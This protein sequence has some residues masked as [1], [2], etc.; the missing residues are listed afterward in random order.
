MDTKLKNIPK[1]VGIICDGNGRW[2]KY[3]GLLRIAGH[4]EGMKVVKNISYACAEYGVKTVSIY[5]FS[6]ENWS[7]PKN[8]VD[9]LMNLLRS[10]L[11]IQYL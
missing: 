9:F 1:H 4:K 6:T 8:E 11:C 5:A 2:G 10:S 3:K 7:C